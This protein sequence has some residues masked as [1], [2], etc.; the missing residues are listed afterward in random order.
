MILSKQN[1]PAIHPIGDISFAE[2]NSYVLKNGIKVFLFPGSKN[3]I[4]SV[5][6]L[7]DAGRWAEKNR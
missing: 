2:P 4:L 7:F 1:F 5:D 3:D 6:F